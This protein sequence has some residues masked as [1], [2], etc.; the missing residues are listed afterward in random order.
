MCGNP[1]RAGNVPDATV[2]AEQVTDTHEPI[3]NASMNVATNTIR[4]I[5]LSND[6]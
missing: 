1:A 6:L 4:E 3:R 5:G 2:H